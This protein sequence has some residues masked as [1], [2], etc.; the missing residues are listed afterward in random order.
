MARKTLAGRLILI[1]ED[2]ALISMEIEN[3]FKA[4]GARVRICTTVEDSMVVA[5][6]ADLAAAVMNHVLHD[7]ESSPVCERLK[8][9]DIPFVLFSGF[10]NVQGACRTGVKV[11]KPTTGA[12][13]LSTVAGLL[14]PHLALVP[15]LYPS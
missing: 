3:T 9:R 10:T 14:G 13:L 12:I 1:A 11:H 8:E 7:G 2:E 15:K 4:A 6:D 5:E